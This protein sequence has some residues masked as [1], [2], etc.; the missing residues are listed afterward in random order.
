V[1]RRAV[2]T[3]LVVAQILY[4][5]YA[6]A[7][8]VILPDGRTQTAVSNSGSV[9]E[10]STSTLTGRNAFNSFH[11][12]SVGPGN[13][14]NL[15]VPSSAQNL[16]NIVRDQRTDIYG[17]L[18][19]IKDGQIGGNV[20]FVNPHGF[21][22]GAGGVVNVGSLTV[23]TPTQRFV[24]DF[25]TAPGV[26]NE[27]S[28]EQL[29]A[30]TA[31]RN[32]AAKIE[33]LGRINA[34]EDIRLSAGAINVAGS[35]YSGAR[36]VGAAPDFTDV[37]NVNGLAGATNVVVREGR[38]EIVAD[39][40][41][42]VSGTMAAPGGSGV[43]G[44]DIAIRAGGDVE[45]KDGALIAARGSGDASAG[46]TVNVWAGRD[47]VARSGALVDA[48]AGG[49]GDGGAI[50]FSAHRTVELAG[51]EFR[52]E[53]AG[54][55]KNGSVL[56][57]PTDVVI[58]ANYYAGGANYTIAADNSITVNPG[59]VVSTRNVA[60]GAGADQETAASVGHSGN[61]TL[62]AGSIAL[63]SGSKL[64]AHADGGFAPG[65][66]T[67]TAARNEGGEARITADHAKITGGNVSL[68]AAAS[69]DDSTLTSWLPV[70]VPQTVSAID[71][72]SGTIDAAG[73]LNLVATSRI[74]AQSSGI[75][76]L[77]IITATSGASVDVHGAS[78][79]RS[80]GNANLVANSTV[81]AKATPGGPNP[82]TLPGDAGVAINV[83]SS[84]ARTH[85]GDSSSVTA[86]ALELSARN[87]VTATTKA[88]A[89]A[90]G[91][92][93]IGGTLALSEVTSVTQAIIDG[94]ATTN[95]TALKVGAESANIVTTSAKA[96]NK[97][98]KKQTETERA[99]N[100]SQSEAALAKYKDQ[101]TTADGGVD[102][103]AAIA[104]ANVND[105]MLAD[106]ASTGTQTA[107][108]AVTVSSKAS[109]ASTVTADGSSVSG[110]VGVGAAVGINI[111]ILDSLARVAD[112]ASISSNGLTVSAV[113]PTSTAKNSLVT[114]AISGAGASN[115]GVAGAL[116]T[117]VLVNTTRAILQGDK[118]NSGA[119]AAIDTG[120]GD[121]LVQAANVSES[122]VTSGASVKPASGATPASVGVGASVGVNVAVNTTL[123]EIEDGAR[124]SGA[125]DLELMATGNHTANTSVTGG[126][127][128]GNVAVTPVV[129]VTAAVN[130]TTARLGTGSRID[131]SGAYT[132]LADHAGTSTT[133]A[134]G[135]TQ[136]DNVA[137]GASIAITSASDTVMAEIDRDITAVGDVEVEAKSTSK[138]N[139]T[140]T[141]SVKGGEKANADGTPS[142]G[143]NGA[144]GQTV[145][146]K[147]AAQSNAA[148]DMGGK[149]G[150]SS[151]G[152]KL[153][154]NTQ[155][156]PKAETSE[157]GVSVAAAVGVNV[158]SS[159]TTA[160]V[161]KGSAITSS[162]ALKV[163]STNETDTAARADG[164]QVDSSGS[165]NVGVGAAVALN[166]GV[167]T[168]TSIVSDEAHVSTQGL[169]VSAKVSTGQKSDASAWAKSGA[170]AGNVGVAGSLAINSATNT[171]VASVE[172]DADHD[173]NVAQVDAHGG[174]VLIESKNATT[175]ESTV[176]AHVQ[177][178]GNNAK[179][180][181][182]A[183]VGVNVAAN[184]TV[185]EVGDGAVLTG[186]R[187]LS[188]TAD[189]DHMLTTAVT[190]GAA[191][192]KI[193]ITPVVA[194][195]IALDTTTARIGS[196]ATA[197]NPAENLSIS[198]QNKNVVTTT[199]TGQTQGDVAVGAALGV[200]IA[201]EDVTAS[202]ERDVTSSGSVDLDAKS[203]LR[204]DTTA[205][206][207]AKGAKEQKK[208]DGT[209]ETGT[210]VD[211]QKKTQL[212]F[213]KS[214]NGVTNNNASVN[215]DTPEAKT[216]DTNKDETGTNK[217]SG[218]KVSVAAAI[219]VGVASNGARARIGPNVSVGTNGRL[220]IN[221]QTDTDY[222]SKA[223]GEAV[224]DETGIAAAVAVTAT[225]NQTQANLGAGSTVT[226]AGDIEIGAISRQNRGPDHLNTTGA[227]AI[228]GASGG[229]VAVAGAL[230]VVAN[231][232]ETRASVDEGATIGTAGTPV[233]DITVTA[234]DE[235]RLA[236]A[237]RAGALSIGGQSKAG[238]GASFAVLLANN[239]NIAS[240][241][242]DADHG[243]TS[244]VSNIFADSV[245]VTAIKHG[246]EP[247]AYPLSRFKDV[248]DFSFDALDPA[249][250]LGINYY[251][252][253]VA[254]SASKG[255]AAVSG[256]FAVNVFN[257]T[258]EA[259]VGKNVHLT[260]GGSQPDD[261]QT[262]VTVSAHADT[263]AAAFA[264]AVAGAQKAGVGISNTAI[265]NNDQTRALVGQGSEVRADKG[266]KVSADV[267][268][269]LANASVSAAGAA[270]SAGVGGVLGVVVSRNTSQALI[271]AAATVKSGGDVAV[272][273]GNDTDMVMI[274]G[275]LG[276]A[277][278]AGVGGSIAVN[279]IQNE[280]EAAIGDG[281]VVD[282]RGGLTVS[283]DARESAVT[284]TLAGA[285]GGSAGVGGALSFNIVQTTTTASVGEGAKINNDATYAHV[286]QAVAIT[287]R[288]DTE[289]VGVSGGGAGG[290]NVG[291]GAAL[292]TA[293]VDKKVKAFVA[294]DDD[295]ADVASVKAAKEVR[296]DAT[297]SDDIVSVTMGFAGGGSTGVGGAVSVGVV[298]ND[299]EAYIGKSASVDADGN[300]LVNAQDDVTAVLT[301]GAGAG[302][303]T[304]GVGASLA[305]AT[306]LGTTKAYVGENATVNARGNRDAATV[307]GGGT[308]ITQQSDSPTMPGDLAA[309]HTESARGLSVTAYNREKLVTTVVGGAGGGTAG[310]AGTVS[311]NVIA[312]TTE[313]YI[314]RGAQINASNGAAGSAQQVRVKAGDE[315][316]LIDSAG[317]GAG[318]GAAGIGAAGNVAVVA[319]TTKAW[320]GHG[321]LVNAKGAVELDATSSALTFGTTAGFAGGGSA[322]VGGAVAGLG[323][324]NTTMAYVEDGTAS[325]YARINVT[326]GK[327]E[328]NATDFAT[329]WLVTG[330]G[331]GGGAAG[332]GGSLSVGVNSSTTKAK[333][334]D[335]AETNA[336]GDT[337]VHADSTENLN[338][339]TVAGAGGGAAGV[340]GS[341]GVNVV[342][343]KTEAGIGDHAKVNQTLT[344]QNVD[345]KA[346]D[347]IISVGAAGAGAGG[348]AAGVGGTANVMVALNTTS[349]YIGTG[350]R[351]K[352]NNDVKVEATSEKSVNSV[353]VAGAGGGAAGVA[354]AVS[355]IAVGALLDGEA[356]NGLRTQDENGNT[357][358]TQSQADGQTTKSAVGDMLGT[359]SQANEAKGV[360][361]GNASR[362]AVSPY[363]SNTTTVPLRNTQAFI[364]FDADVDAGRD[365]KVS[366]KDTTLA[367][368][369]SGAGAGG[370]AAGVAG[371]VG[372]MLLHDSAEAFIANGAT[373]DAARTISVDADTAETVVN[374]GVTGCGGGA[375]G[376]CGAGSVNVVTSATSAYIGDA[377]INQGSALN[378]GRSVEVN[379][380]SQS[381][382]IT[383][384]GS[385]GGAGAAA[386]GGVLDVNTLSKSTKAFIGEGA[387][388]SA[389]KDVKVVAES[390]QNIVSAGLSIQG[391]GGA[392][393]GGAA[394]VNVVANTTEAFIGSARDDTTKT[395]A[396]VD[397]DGN[398]VIAA[399]DD[400]ML[401]AASGTG[402][403]SGAAAVG[404]A[405]GANVVSNQTRAYV[406]DNTVINARGNAD[407]ALV[408]TGTIDH[409]VAG[410]LP[411]LP[412]GASGNVDVDSDGT[413]DGTVGSGATFNLAG[414]S[415]S[416]T[417]DPSSAKDSQG[418]GIG[419]ATG[420]LGAKGKETAKGLSV[421]ATANEKI[422]T[423]AIG[424]A[425]AGA[426]G[427]TGTAT[428]D[429]IVSQTEARIGDGAR[430][431]QSG[432]V[433]PGSDVRVRAADNSLVVMASGTVA[434]GGV[435]GV[436]GSANVAVI[437]KETHATVGDADVKAHDVKID[438]AGREDVYVIDANVSGGA[439]G[440]GG[441]VGV[442]VVTNDTRAGIAAGAT[443]D[444]T[445]GIA[446]K[447]EQNTALDIY[448]IA[449]SAGLDA[450]SGAFSI[451]VIDNNTRAYVEDGTA[452]QYATLDA[453]GITEVAATSREKITTGTASAAG[454][455]VG[456]A[457]AVGVK[458][459][460]SETTAEI[461]DYA[462]INQTRRGA[463][464][465][466]KVSASDTVHLGG[467]GG[468]GAVGSTFGAG[469][470]AEVNVVRNT[471]TASIG[472]HA[473][474][475]TDRD[476]E[477]TATSTK[478]VEAQA[479][480]LAG[481]IGG[482]AGAVALAFIGASVQSDN[483]AKSAIGDGATA[484]KADE[485]MRADNVAGKLGDSE[486]V[487]GTK[488]LITSRS[489]T[490]GVSGELN[491]T[492]SSSRDKTRAFVG[493]DASL[494]AGDD[495][496]I[497]AT[498]QTR[499]ALL[500]TGAG[501][502]AAGI[503]AA[504]GVG[505][506][507]S[508]T[509]AFVDRST[510]IEAA[511]DID[512]AARA[513]N[514]DG[515]GSTVTTTAGAGGVIGASASVAVL[516]DAS[517]TRAHVGDGVEMKRADA[518]TV[519]A[520]TSRSSTATT[521]GASAGALAVGASVARTSFT[522]S[523]EAFLANDIT[524]GRATGKTV[525]D[526][527]VAATDQSSGAASATA[528]TAGI[529]SGSGAEAKA[530]VDSDVTAYIGNDADIVAQDDVTVSATARPGAKA[531]SFGVN[532]GAAAVGVSLATASVTG[533]TRAYVGSGSD[534]KAD[535]LAVTARTDLSSAG[536]TAWAD[537]LGSAG[538]LIGASGSD[539]RAIY[540]GSTLAYFDGDSIDGSAAVTAESDTRQRASASGIAAGI[541][542]VGANLATAESTNTTRASLGDSSRVSGAS[543]SVT[544]DGNDDNF[545][546]AVSGSGG[547]I[548]G[549][550]AQA[551]TR[552]TSLT[553]AR[554]AGN[555]AVDRFTLQAVHQALF[556]GEVD[557]VNAAV[558][559]A[560]GAWA[561]HTAEG[562]V[563]AEIGNDSHVQAKH[564]DID[565]S[566]KVKKD[567]LGGATGGDAAQ[568][569]IRS[570]SGGVI[571]A[572]AGKSESHVT[573]TTTARVGDRSD[574][575][576][577]AT[578]PGDGTFTMDAYNEVV[579]R[580]KAKLDSGGAIAVAKSSSLFL[581]ERAD[582]TTQF[583]SNAQV[584]SDRGNIGAG[585][586]SR[587]DL[588]TRAVADTYGLAGAPDGNAYSV[589]NG[590]NQLI[591]NSGALLRAD[592][593]NV[594]LAGGQSSTG[595][596]TSIDARSTVNLWN[597]TAIP[598]STT[599]DAQS[600]VLS[601][602][603][604]QLLGTSNV[605]A[606]EDISLYA[607]KGII[608]A[609]ASGIG[610]D[611]Y[612]ETASA[613]ASGISNLVGGGDVSFDI[614]GGSTRV[615]GFAQIRVDGT[616][617]T[618][619]HRNESLTLDTENYDASDQ[620]WNLKITKTRGIADPHIDFQ[621]GIA[622][623][624][625]AR[626]A[627][628]RNLAD[629]YAGTPAAD[630]YN[631]EIAF[632]EHKL[633]DLGLAKR[634][635]DGTITLGTGGGS[636]ISPQ[637]AA[638]NLR[639]SI[640]AQ[641]DYVVN[642]SLP[643]VL[644][645]WNT[646]KTTL[647]N[648]NAALA[649]ANTNY[650]HYQDRLTALQTWATE[651][652]KPPASQNPTVIANA[653]TA[654][655][656]AEQAIAGAHAEVSGYVRQ[657]PTAGC[658]GSSPNVAAATTERNTYNT[659]VVAPA[660][661]AQVNAQNTFDPIDAQKT[662]L[663]TQRDALNASITSLNSRIPTLSNVAVS[664]PAADFVTVPD[665]HAQL[666]S[667]MVKGDA[668]VGSGRLKAP[669]D[670]KVTITNN[671]SDYLIVK[672]ITIDSEAARLTFNGFEVNGNTDINR[673]NA[674][675]RVANF[676]EVV[677]G[678]S[679]P[680]LPEVRIISNY[681][682]NNAA[683][684]PTGPAPDIR[685]TGTITNTRGL[686]QVHS[687]A[688][689]ILSQG[690]IRAGTV[691]V[692]A[693]NGDF[694][695]S[696]V[697]NFFHAG[698]DPRTIYEGATSPG[699]ILANGSVFIS[700]RYL[701]INGTVQSGIDSWNLTLPAG[702]AV[703]T[704]SAATL[705]VS[706]AALDAYRQSYLNAPSSVPAVT[707]FTNDRGA[708]VT[709]DASKNRL[710]VS[711]Q[712]AREDYTY[713]QA[714]GRNPTGL[715]GLVGDYGNIGANYDPV[716]D[717][718]LINGTEVKGGY[719]QLFGQIMNT[720]S[721][722][723]GTGTGKLRV[724]D[725]Y[726]QINII[727][728]SG[729][730][731]VI[732]K[733]DTGRG[734]AGVI[735]I[736]DLQF[737]DDNNVPH[738]I[739]SVITREN[740]SVKINQTGR[741]TL[742]GSGL[743][744]SF[745]DNWTATSTS[746]SV[747]GATGPSGSASS[748]SATYN[749]QPGLAF[750]YTIGTDQSTRE[751]FS[752][753][754][755]QFLGWDAL[756]LDPNL[757][758][759]RIAGPYTIASAELPNGRYLLD[760][761]PLGN[762]YH[763]QS[764]YTI[765]NGPQQLFKT[766]EYSYC[767]WWSVCIT[768]TYHIDFSRITPT[769]QI[770]SHYLRADNPIGIEFIGA[771]NG[772]VNVMSARNVLLTGAINNQAGT[773]TIW[774]GDS[775]TGVTAS[776]RNIVQVNDS[777]LV[778]T[779]DL[780]LAA[781]GSIG[782]PVG[783]GSN[784]AVRVAASGTVNANATNG[785][786]LIDQTIGD[787]KIGSIAAAGSASAGL[788]RVVLAADGDIR[789]ESG[790]SV[791]RGN[792]LDLTSANG[793]IGSIAAPLKVEV[794]YGDDVAQRGYYGLKAAAQDDI[795]IQALQWSGN[796][797][798]N[799]L[800]NTVVSSGGD[801]KLVALGRIIDNNPIEQVDTRTW[802]EL[803]AYWDSIGLRAGTPE[804]AAKQQQA[805]KAYEYAK[806]AEYQLY[807]QMRNRQRDPSV[808]D[809]SFV[810]TATAAERAALAASGMTD[811]QIASFE[812]NRAAQYHRL[813]GEVGGLNGG[814]YS[815]S[816]AYTA[817]TAER[818]AI[819]N[820]SSWTERE[821]GIS[822]APGMLKTVTNTNPVVKSANVQGRN[823]TLEAG[824]A[825][826]ETAG[827]T[828]IPTNIQPQD[829]TDAQKVALAAA[830]RS[831]VTVTDTQITITQRKP[832]N[833]DAITALNVAIPSTAAGHADAGKAF[834]ASLGDGRLGDIDVP[835]ETRIKVRGSIVNASPS[836]V[837]TGNLILE[838]ANGGIGYIPAD[839][840]N[841][842]VSSPLQLN[843]RSGAQLIARAASDV[844]VV[845]SGDLNLDTVYSRANIRLT[846]GGSI[847]DADTGSE[848]N[849][850]ADNITLTATAGSIGTSGNPLDAGVELV[851]DAATHRTNL[852]R[853][854]ATSGMGQSIY[855]NGPLGTNFNIGR[856][857]SGDAI[858]LSSDID[859]LIDGSVSGPGAI[860]LVAGGT[861]TMA[862]W[863]D[864][865]ATNL[866]VILRADAL[867]M[868]DARRMADAG[869]AVDPKYVAGIDAAQM[870][871]DV[872]TIDIET[873]GDA[874]ITGIETGNGTESAIRV[875]SSAGRILDNGDTRLDIIADTPPAAKLTISAA[876][877]IGADPLE[878]R[879]LNLD[880]TSGGVVDLAV[881]G[882]VNIDAITAADRVWLTAG[883]DITGNTV[884]STGTVTGSDPTNPMTG[885][886]LSSTGGSVNL[887]GVSG[888][889]G[890]SV[891][892]QTGVTLG[893]LTS[894]GGS[895]VV[896]SGGGNVNVG[897]AS[898]DQNV[899]FTSAAGLVT[900][901][902][903]TA[904]SG[905]TANAAQDMALGSATSGG[906][907]A[908]NAGGNLAASSL[909]S[910]GGSVVATSAGGIVIDNV[911]AGVNV[912][913]SAAGDVSVG[914]GSAGG[915]FFLT[916]SGGDVDVGMASA[917]QNVSFTSAAGLVTVTT[918]TAGSGFT[919]NAAQDMALG[920]ATS[921]GDMALNAGGNLAASSLTSTGGSVVATSGGGIVIDN[922][923]AGVNVGAS[924]AGDVSVGSGSAGGNFFLTSSGGD[925]DVGMASAPTISLS[926][927]GDVTA[928]TL[929]VGSSVYLGAD[930]IYAV[931]NGG[932]GPVTGSVTGF[933]GGIASYVDL[934]LSG[935][936]GFA[937]SDFWA[938]SASVDIPLGTL[939]IASVL[940]EDRATF[941]NPLTLVLVD[942]HDKR[943][944]PADIQLYSGGDAFFLFLRDNSLT[945]D[946]FVIHRSPMHETLTQDGAP[947]VTAVEMGDNVLALTDQL[948]LGGASEEKNMSQMDGTL[949]SYAGVP[950]SIDCDT[951]ED[952]G[953]MK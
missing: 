908:L 825:V 795:G 512:I 153:N 301:A 561:E 246:I 268:Q 498:D 116:G 235:S 123:S 552:T 721:P 334:G 460:T 788:G 769:K 500:V 564:V 54:G 750:V 882:S 725:G 171:M 836:P 237:A 638:I 80:V 778:K 434:A 349:A 504:I 27:V 782:L 618:G 384:A 286:N 387:N 89:T 44:G 854:V 143:S 337:V 897:T 146:Q 940:I 487:Q 300:V 701:N 730:D 446:V 274:S 594:F 169:Q 669:G 271:D 571:D 565:A 771:D 26:P 79:L 295:G 917:D 430:I 19:S 890:A 539:S 794:G 690:N 338:T 177:G 306:L 336:S 239:K 470:T 69:Y 620:S 226:R 190:G 382:L 709:Y 687:A 323:V 87:A 368:V 547:V 272:T 367:V 74:D 826:G 320:I 643:P 763:T 814:V 310:V 175:S 522:G 483:D 880:A 875:V 576:V 647:D 399:S 13:T 869:E 188:V 787:L 936:G 609:T 696:Y 403:G 161:G 871:V 800:L 353:T 809:P 278:E 889:A 419:S 313:A 94:S 389:D 676:S 591:L 449:G 506:T 427:V 695:Q 488:T 302:G 21:I 823:V 799:L 308:V 50:E 665:I 560:S 141:A 216:P 212:D 467:G 929:N 758:D 416:T 934:T 464:Q 119:G 65:D 91:A 683:Y 129:A 319:K 755:T 466:V 706:Q 139:A 248:E 624:I 532:A 137:V 198:A 131:L 759:Y 493:Q 447:A 341:I 544:A 888:Q 484:G 148:K 471:T 718:Y 870:R 942:Q 540:S 920:S 714:H 519:T 417:V 684:P 773:T 845:Q 457:G 158:G 22:V 117:N 257:N 238:V 425:G 122:R 472:D 204:L 250:Y 477:V 864:V 316:L 81:I 735:D 282:A 29:L 752:Y 451:G 887:V 347:R 776:N 318:G 85:L 140:S 178:T 187:N 574:I 630:A 781:S 689:S 554:A 615:G 520:N 599:P 948:A 713:A 375:A 179:V 588:D 414:G 275:G 601:N 617:M 291:V 170:G 327:L 370:G 679:N 462:R 674:P 456:V 156:P 214:R 491:D 566:N 732:A 440:V 722:S 581:V 543:L 605:E 651:A 874:R 253:A 798:G 70:S 923:A 736:T 444:A 165:A 708:S 56:I 48:S 671:T 108:G 945:T 692:R 792:W 293:V 134:T 517:T 598:I 441:A 499:I 582:A 40:D 351:V 71:I 307:Y 227:E 33:I 474:V 726:G 402:T 284:A 72:D 927:P 928:G 111:G 315:T 324:A 266:V 422:V 509:E 597:K 915:N 296:I 523:T 118:D 844:D 549:A 180:G 661:T 205:T 831:D 77:G 490:L 650:G 682:P 233:G 570:G 326:G 837:R 785:N 17:I 646:A 43:R 454:G 930:N 455:G 740:G 619:I 104:I 236:A 16:I 413:N 51:G 208:A 943:I 261:A 707:T 593:G 176:S 819:L 672:D 162:G 14:V 36:F 876:G 731:I 25:F 3:I 254:G 2:A 102:V 277:R 465:D 196:G 600:N 542:A 606:A 59:I 211:E 716:N 231:D 783:A 415:T 459:V 228:S 321:A 428:A 259:S 847:L 867:T 834:L 664:G 42:A 933:G 339:I 342:V 445:G 770:T 492:T 775:G 181:V 584:I 133:T 851:S 691:D 83:I 905:F 784:G 478:R 757:T 421:T 369:A 468:A 856:V 279:I 817:S 240:L 6:A 497:R 535:L 242:Y 608:N 896:T 562:T 436:S 749:P 322:G 86:G 507:K 331:A 47:A 627:F 138:S 861:M 526:V 255:D 394:T 397:S 494:L 527:L 435:A 62:Q 634:N 587:V 361:D 476:I 167:A 73:T 616:A 808:Y 63:G 366:A 603:G 401:I 642:T 385:G 693:N 678:T 941:T 101:A 925:V 489:A 607:D 585:T 922:V 194:A 680:S 632:L 407:G 193:S 586:R 939:S 219:G 728:P 663:E 185:A 411:A 410:A 872:G 311:A 538:G 670:A 249:N 183:S 633:V 371:S 290:G 531:Q 765:S 653:K 555:L 832:L 482:V 704:G 699:G 949:V 649:T 448:T 673:I 629:K 840:I 904:G 510:T 305:V 12:F 846:A 125:H 269:T 221:A 903:M 741:W 843:L 136:G 426:A 824:V 505:V 328:L 508:T 280:T 821:L 159:T 350:T 439:A 703:L 151:V 304:A 330:A 780:N 358:S 501:G 911:A 953:C 288:D 124:I 786:V 200:S 450:V 779:K 514:A 533:T 329:S 245:K 325:N 35:I 155:T 479:Y 710:E 90:G 850:L 892:G 473:N 575:H 640:Q 926:G 885:V 873:A 912:G 127:A 348:G 855:L 46:G 5:S 807:W 344:G 546:S 355:V 461:G 568:W 230:A 252:E 791:L 767:D 924:A 686:V 536:Y 217:E 357:V 303:G 109:S 201:M 518:F 206:A 32:E 88:D 937:L 58:S 363:L 314:G 865:H 654:V 31:P 270:G 909:T 727:N 503:G 128:G 604:V 10:V 247:S 753:E 75:S 191:G 810:Y 829:L 376:V 572:P 273:A 751:D 626:I 164:S 660:T 849:V 577:I 163:T 659:T 98:A 877:G 556:N 835:G 842:A 652:A 878:V 333:I 793:A 335:Y 947:N 147:V 432:A 913:A 95:S 898:A 34:G 697:D 737:I 24:D 715:Y 400:T 297:S 796:P 595:I 812:A 469:A 379:A 813:H 197:L 818:D 935:A 53:G 766:N 103:A 345:V 589:Y 105:T 777:A 412:A 213:A 914:S 828:V 340:T 833:F 859:M 383:V 406:G 234:E 641:Y 772:T 900:V 789:A 612:R 373:V 106:I 251:S 944:Q 309:K 173:G 408:D 613:I 894:T 529:V 220:S 15:I 628:L 805:I 142:G 49:S 830:E 372:V 431:N 281:A 207:G 803:L 739:K 232:N 495:I 112:N 719:I 534:I 658:G 418:N 610:K 734:A 145:D 244:P 144:P 884:T 602:A 702:G 374:I 637:Q 395:A 380:A 93:A 681:D 287:A 57:D 172:G 677:T 1:W 668:L 950:V 150:G 225:R 66:V 712:F 437:A 443:L 160:K 901:T 223:S 743:P 592:D 675:G 738:Y 717:R 135:Q 879:L 84:T 537:S 453:G 55:G 364:G 215:T 918:M 182:G 513:Q 386:V 946:S 203:A 210:T 64:L 804:N 92:T 192:A 746:S 515:S 541:V 768:Q 4:P 573:L 744:V 815:A 18:N 97:G 485:Q 114:T 154:A 263:K 951:D 267:Q 256:A 868:Q 723:A 938:A 360:L 511:D 354:G 391:A 578:A 816:Y 852:G 841:P 224:S 352:A 635:A 189:S 132:S 700:A 764:S 260:A 8:T 359:S 258:T 521:Y 100:P 20:W 423:A 720:A 524:I 839:G 657:C 545:A 802:N 9:Y 23:T 38:I 343:S 475:R 698:G 365:V 745:D 666:G 906:D 452:S 292:D 625:N 631:A 218:K 7:Q 294:D 919:A 907:M 312:N 60:G 827:A 480:A 916:S 378:T 265:V 644:T 528:G 548:A 52:A 390:G 774:A 891:S 45:L 396:N 559:G 96:A 621:V 28:V 932:T 463:A 567:W 241:G 405:V 39:G 243:G 590:N 61:L 107:T 458:V 550:A 37:V 747:V 298:K 332:V 530:V 622:A 289:I 756:R 899:S 883:G 264:G 596:P 862:P 558:A 276:G 895:V 848:L 748:R 409:T 68:T 157:G 754:G 886:T 553:E 115:V 486:H 811:A 393:V 838:A 921:G 392:A 388:V 502:G 404:V 733:L 149:T 99:A 209:P 229:E 424:V 910:T 583:G 860:S 580:D 656:N 130:S 481:G 820:K 168:T 420:G 563:L 78:V 186:G 429:V 195:T 685:L 442:A 516:D 82:A 377:D 110:S 30:G 863:A 152:N 614:H 398:V 356:K 283:A 569:N 126:A 636:G 893:T 557:S 742:D 931:I 806:T 655:Y 496:G 688:G 662:E 525:N 174:D 858:G 902:T 729:K 438:A 611:I 202:V 285:G 121:V 381:N 952:D 866:G 166:V 346:T 362:L 199:A 822:I 853:I 433:T 262:G 760:G 41:V 76:P 184:N 881:Q 551:T 790:S 222:K 801:V 623:D 67:L 705:G 579:G 761:Q 724:L 667:I 797:A 639:D 120:G 694:V 648:A 711:E 299:V 645:Q 317:A 857:A 11:A 113:M 762:A